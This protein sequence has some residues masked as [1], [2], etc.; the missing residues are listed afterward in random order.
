MSKIE[1]IVHNIYCLKAIIYFL[2][3]LFL[4]IWNPIVGILFVSVPIILVALCFA[5]F[6][7][8]DLIRDFNNSL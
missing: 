8:I 1:L 7:V 5:F 4:T 3:G 2:I 6:I